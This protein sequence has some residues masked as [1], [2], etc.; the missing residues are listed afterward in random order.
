[1]DWIIIRV[2]HTGAGITMFPPSLYVGHISLPSNAGGRARK[3]AEMLFVPLCDLN[4][5]FRIRS[6]LYSAGLLEVC[7]SGFQVHWSR[8]SHSS[9]PPQQDKFN[10]IS[11][12]MR[13]VDIVDVDESG[14]KQKV[15]Q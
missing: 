5:T 13:G 8:Q 2:G 4:D 3:V 6:L 11:N 7:C 10:N 14:R 15:T 9:R 1:M 12:I